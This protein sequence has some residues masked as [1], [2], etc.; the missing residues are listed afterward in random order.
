ME[1]IFEATKRPAESL[2]FHKNDRHDI[3][4]GDIVSTSPDDYA[5]ANVVIVGCPYDAGD[6][7]AGRR[8][9]AAG[10]P[11]AIRTE[12]YRLS[13]FG[14]HNRVIDIGDI[15]GDD[16]PDVYR[17]RLATVAKKVLGDGKR[18]IVLGGSGDIAYPAGDAMGSIFGS[19][20]WL[21]INIDARLDVADD[22]NLT[23]ES[24]FGKLVREER[25]LSRYLY[26]IAFQYCFVAHPLY[27]Q[28][29]DADA[30]LISLALLRSRD[31]ADTELRETIRLEFIHHSRTMNVFFCFDLE[32]VRA[33]EAPGVTEPSPFGLR[34]G[35][36]LTLTEF[37]AD[38][39]NTKLFLFCSVNP[40]YDQD[41]HTAKLVAT[42]IYRILSSK[43]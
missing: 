21:G 5:S 34:A 17:E 14:V 22:P 9:G 20:R 19:D 35:E 24:A 29:V 28:I 8:A 26:L 13:N 1:E 39:V 3:R 32:A 41:S 2:F 31:A 27:R 7:L 23:S 25:L 30:K 10:A 42:A 15:V 43:R 18:L 16:D 37:A 40:L 6:T 36:F 38:L 33:S 12:L 4:L 11:D